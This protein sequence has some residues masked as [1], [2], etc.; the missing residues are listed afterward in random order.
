[1]IVTSADIKKLLNEGFD[2]IYWDLAEEFVVYEPTQIKL[3][4]GSNT[5][6][7]HKN[8]DIRF[9]LGG[10]YHGSPYIFE[11]FSTEKI[12]T[13]EGAQAF[14]WGLYFTDF[15]EIARDYAAKLSGLP[16]VLIDGKTLDNQ[17][18]SQK[19]VLYKIADSYKNLYKLKTAIGEKANLE[20]V[21][22]RVENERVVLGFYLSDHPLIHIKKKYNNMSS[23]ILMNVSN[24]PQSFIA[25]IK[26]VKQH[27]TKNGSMMAFL[28]VYDESGEIDCVV[29]PNV[30]QLVAEQLKNGALIKIE[31]IIEKE[32]SCFVKKIDMIER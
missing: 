25:M 23:I 22:D 21:L 1:M 15:E 6:F 18:E 32:K 17:T 13:G 19:S 27:R 20:D 3:A 12:G 4:D 26:K 31:G 9:Q 8:P 14:G 29:M 16:N 30:Y 7:D 24:S 2:G 28:S 5:T 10:I 11:K